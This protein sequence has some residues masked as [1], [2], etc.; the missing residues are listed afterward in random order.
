MHSKTLGILW[1][2]VTLGLEISED[3]SSPYN[4]KIEK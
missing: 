4:Y 1:T 3:R 2:R